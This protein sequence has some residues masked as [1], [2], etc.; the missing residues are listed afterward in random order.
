MPLYEV[1]C[2]SCNVTFPPEARQCIHCGARLRPDRPAAV[3][4]GPRSSGFEIS[5]GDLGQSGS[6]VTTALGPAPS[7]G[8]QPSSESTQPVLLEEEEQEPVR[9]SLLRAGMTVV[10]MVL[11]AAGYAWRACSQQ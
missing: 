2:H 7:S 10:W 1:W 8:G 3:S 9:R 11:L 4:R 6:P 5:Y